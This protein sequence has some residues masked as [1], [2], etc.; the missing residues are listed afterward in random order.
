MR[1]RRSVGL[2]KKKA[3]IRFF[4]SISKVWLDSNE[5]ICMRTLDNICENKQISGYFFFPFVASMQN[6]TKKKMIKTSAIKDVIS[7][8]QGYIATNKID[9]FI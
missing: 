1:R 7:K 3:L 5:S 9:I 8:Q 2:Y 6:P 4:M